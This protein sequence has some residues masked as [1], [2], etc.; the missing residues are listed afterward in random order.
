MSGTAKKTLDIQLVEPPWRAA[1]EQRLQRFA[2]REAWLEA[3]QE[4]IGGSEA[5][6][7]MGASPWGSPYQ[8]WTE[9]AGLVPPDDFETEILRFGR[10]IEPHIAAEY[11]R[12]TG[13]QLVE[14]G[15]WAIRQHPTFPY[16]FCTHDRIIAP[17]DGRGPG[18]L[19]I[20]SA[21]MWRGVEWLEDEE[22]PLPYQVQFQHELACSGLS[23]GSF[24]VL[25]W[26]KGVRWV[27]A[28]RNDAFI[29]ELEVQC[30]EFWRRVRE[31]DPPPVDGSDHTT[32][33]LRRLHPSETGEV[34][35]L[36]AEA[37]DWAVTIEACEAQIKELTAIKDGL[38]NR[39]R[40]LIGDASE[41]YVPGGPA[42]T[43]RLSGAKPGLP[44][45]WVP[46]HEEPAVPPYLGTRRLL[47]KGKKKGKTS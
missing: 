7:I 17:I 45:R 12:L 27:D 37:A 21:N 41:G 13:R 39:V 2:S 16:M 18:V 36:P 25:I 26:G 23:W 28:T 14:L 9:K 11:G 42:W 33:A 40:Q 10:V 46:E 24:A 31:G 20:K 15:E 32:Q 30:G 5:A 8:L 1:V 35:E 3:R 6:I 34:I 43:Y 4:G 29:T 38:R 22:P 44:A 47:R 19:S